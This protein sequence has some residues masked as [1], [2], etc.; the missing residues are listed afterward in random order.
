[1]V[2]CLNKIKTQIAAVISTG[3]TNFA[4]SLG[5]PLKVLQ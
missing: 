5:Q 2:S 1:M 3:L 4:C